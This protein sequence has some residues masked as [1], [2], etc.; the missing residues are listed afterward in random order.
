MAGFFCSHTLHF[1]SWIVIAICS[2]KIPLCILYTYI[3]RHCLLKS[4]RFR[5]EDTFSGYFLQS[6]FTSYFCKQVGFLHSL[7]VLLIEKYS[8]LPQTG[9]VIIFLLWA[10]LL[11]RLWLWWLWLVLLRLV[12]HGSSRVLILGG[13]CS[14]LF[15]SVVFLIHFV[16]ADETF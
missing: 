11:S 13:S 9:Q 6:L 14:I 1:F 2:I 12:R 16:S 4:L 15:F 8:S 10:R 7:S 5:S 3:F